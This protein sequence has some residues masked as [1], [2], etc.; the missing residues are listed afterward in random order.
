MAPELHFM[1]EEQIQLAKM[2][3]RSEDL[4]SQIAKVAH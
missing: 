4:R 1:N 3:F 2:Y